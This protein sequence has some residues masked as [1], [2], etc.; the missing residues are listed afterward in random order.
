MLFLLTPSVTSSAGTSRHGKA[1]NTDS[2]ALLTIPRCGT[3]FNIQLLDLRP[4]QPVPNVS[5]PVMNPASCCG[6]R[7][8]Y[9]EQVDVGED[10]PRTIISGLVQ[11]VPLEEMQVRYRLTGSGRQAAGFDIRMQGTRLCMGYSGSRVPLKRTAFC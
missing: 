10:E 1:A 2:I 6:V 8:L 11:F 7:S 5:A 3:S 9:V 4:P